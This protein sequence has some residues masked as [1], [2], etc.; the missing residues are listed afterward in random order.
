MNIKN[1]K[2][3][4]ITINDEVISVSEKKQQMRYGLL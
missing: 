4:K 2:N 3:C 1:N